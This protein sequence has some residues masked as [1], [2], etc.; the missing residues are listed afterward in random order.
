MSGNWSIR[1][2]RELL[3]K[4]ECPRCEGALRAGVCTRCGTDLSGPSGTELWDASV[5]AASAIETRQLLINELPYAALR[6]AVVSPAAAVSTPVRTAPAAVET[7]A[8]ESQV[9]VQSV[10][11]VAGAALV[12]IAAF[13]FTFLNPELSDVVTRSLIVGGVTVLFLGSAWLLA[14]SGLQFSAEAVGALGLVFV[15]LDIQAIGG[16]WVGA[17]LATLAFSAALVGLGALAR[18]RSWLFAGLLGA[19][20]APALFG[21][22]GSAPWSSIAGHVSVA[23]AALA[24]GYARRRLAARFDGVLAAE[25]AAASILQVLVVSVVL[26]QLAAITEVDATPRALGTAATL[27]ALAGLAVLAARFELAPFW[28]GVAGALAV[29]AVA[30]VPFAWFYGAWQA[31]ALPTA[32]SLALVAIAAIRA[33]RAALIGASLV[34]AAATLPAMVLGIQL[35]ALPGN[36]LAVSLEA[37]LGLAALAAACFAIVRITGLS[38]YRTTGIWVAVGSVLTVIQLAVLPHLAQL[39]LGILI[40]VGLAL[41]SRRVTPSIAL[42]IGA[43]IAVYLVAVLAWSD[44]STVV[45]TSALAISTLAVVALSVPAPR[46]VIHLGIGYAYALVIF[47]VAIFLRG[48][49]FVIVLALTT[50]VAS[51]TALVA[52]LVRRVSARAWRAILIVTIVPFLFGVISVLIDIRG[53]TGFSTAVTFALA[54]T[55]VFTRR[56]GL[57]TLVRTAAAALLVPALAVV[58]ICV[59]AWRIEASASPIT[60]PIIAVIV[61]VALPLTGWMARTLA[62]RGLPSAQAREVRTWIEASA[63]LTAAIAVLLSLVRVAAGLETT[64]IVLTIVGLGAAATGLFSRRRYAWFV[65]AIAFTGALWSALAIAS[66]TTLEPY[67]LPPALAAALLGAIGALRGLHTVRLYATGLAIALAAPILTITVD[68]GTLW[69]PVAVLTAS[70]ALLVLARLLPALRQPTLLLAIGAAGAGALQAARIG[71]TDPWSLAILP[72]LG[73]SVVAAVLAGFAGRMLVTSTRSRW[74]YA[75]ALG[76]LV[77][78]P[79]VAVRVDL[80]AAWLLWTL[81]LGLLALLVVTATRSGETSLPPVWFTFAIAWGV[82]VAAWSTREWFRVEAFSLPLGIAL[83]IAGAL[84]LRSP[85]D[86]TASP[87]SWPAGFRGSWHL[88]VPGL[89]VTLGPSM[90]ATLTDPQTWRAI[91]VIALALTAILVGS[92]RRLAAP[93]ILGVIV[94][95]IENVLVF[96]VQIGRQIEA[97]PWWITLAT[98]GA[99]LLII[100]ATYERRGAGSRLRDLT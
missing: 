84:V 13:V 42:A 99:A 85:R 56:P 79:I 81:M 16:G 35:L 6:A 69:R 28:N 22:A 5:A 71:F 23:F 93:F 66:I 20:I 8:S 38:L 96:S 87:S 31:T 94:L 58:V 100:A 70:V 83:L 27:A 80:L 92:L 77:A 39:G 53:W 46:R 10:L 52:T 90:L 25:R 91:L 37:T 32:A 14:R 64:F 36:P 55:L 57:N 7:S 75:P 48:E 29:A 61:A 86:V 49:E 44:T 3:K 11:A 65:A 62:R 59:G 67:V 34:T 26:G 15:A 9:S 12:A 45:V 88:L 95:P 47:A 1:V 98:A 2:T 68:G 73:F 78:G 30:A 82:A 43:H 76:Y 40:A 41:A 33:P 60:L 74:V 97:A 17:A 4:H 89:I 72:A 21:Y 24:L 18:I 54:L 19:A 63:L 50:S 51:A